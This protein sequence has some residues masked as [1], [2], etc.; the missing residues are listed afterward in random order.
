MSIDTT[1]LELELKAKEKEVTCLLEDVKRLQNSFSQLK[2]SSS[3][4]ITLLETQLNE[5]ICLVS[6]LENKLSIQK[7]YE[8]MKKE[9]E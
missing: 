1:E 7:D 6:Q 4:H 3:K 5:K 8:E 9:L 2:D